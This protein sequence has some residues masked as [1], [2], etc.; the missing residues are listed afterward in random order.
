MIELHFVVLLIA[1]FTAG[2][3]FHFMAYAETLGSIAVNITYTNGDRADYS[4]TSM[5]IFQDNN[6]I[7]YREID[8]ITGNPFNIVSLPVG[9][10]YKIQVYSNGMY[11][12]ANYVDLEQTQQNANVNIPLPGGMRVNVLYNDGQT[13]VANSSVAVKSQDN[14]TWASGFT[15]L[16]GQTLR[17]WVEPTIY[18]NDHY[19][20]D[21]KI[22]QHLLYSQTPVFL[23]AG[24]PQEVYVNTP[25]PPK[26]NGLIAVKV[27]NNQSKLVSSSDGKFVMDLNDLQGNKIMESP[28]NNRGE[29]DFYNLKVGEYGLR[30]INLND[31]SDWAESSVIVDGTQSNFVVQKNETKV[32]GSETQ[33]TVSQT[34]QMQRIVNCNCVA[35]RLDNVQDYWLDN[36]QIGLIDTFEHKDAS[37][38]MILD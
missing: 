9:H 4:S 32:I 34:P 18:E 26:V 22:G 3:L 30:V 2:L 36:A 33:A 37:L 20:I 1:I 35:F 31:N 10:Q 12:S 21:V 5:K 15:D 27:Y 8:S 6:Q 23:S 38:V 25:W 17:F 29:A 11:S 13:P 28:V 16:N 19:T 14:K 7:P 24:V